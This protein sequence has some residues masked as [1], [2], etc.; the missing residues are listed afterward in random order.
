MGAYFESFRDNE[1]GLGKKGLEAIVQ[2]NSF[3]FQR[4]DRV[5]VPGL[6]RAMTRRNTAVT[7]CLL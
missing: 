1:S 4:G 2:F 5:S 3:G 6:G 7:M